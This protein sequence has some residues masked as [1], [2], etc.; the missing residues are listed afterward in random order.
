MTE[1]ER[2]ERTIKTFNT[3]SD[4]YDNP[5]LRFFPDSAR[6][7][8]SFME[9][10]GY[11]HILDICTGTGTVANEIA[12]TLPH[13][14]V[15]GIDFSEGMLNRAKQ[16]A[17]SVG[18]NN[19]SFNIMDMQNL[20]YP[21]SHFDRASCGFGIFFVDDMV[22][23]LKGIVD[24]VKPGGLMT[25]C[26]FKKGSFEPQSEMFLDRIQKYGVEA[27]PR[28][29]MRLDAPEKNEKLFTDAGLKSIQVHEKQLGYYLKDV[30]AWWDVLWNAGFRGLLDQLS[31]EQLKT[32]RQDHLKEVDQLSDNNSIWLNIDVLYTLGVK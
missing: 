7:M 1:Q 3:V 10:E 11:E 4:G 17:K 29:W 31:D 12:K 5:A 23:T 20:N 8:A 30:H 13:G 24:K 32:F 27:P 26:C 18:L 14:K 25:I 28:S 15:T 22:E 21:T 6:N 2:K 16:K 9:N 19:I